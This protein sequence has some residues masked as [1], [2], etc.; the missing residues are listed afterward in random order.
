MDDIFSF[1]KETFEIF[2]VF[3]NI[4]LGSLGIFAG[5]HSFIK[6]LERNGLTEVV[7]IINAIEFIMEADIFYIS[8]F[9][10]FF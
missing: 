5:I 8:C 6:F 3:G 2:E 9:K 10:M 4:Y 1:G 7:G